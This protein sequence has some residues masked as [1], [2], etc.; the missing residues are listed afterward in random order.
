[1]RDHK[2]LPLRISAELSNGHRTSGSD[3][4]KLYVYEAWED[5]Y[6]VDFELTTISKTTSEALALATHQTE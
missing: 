3:F 2:D 4:G 5:A 6:E 1:M